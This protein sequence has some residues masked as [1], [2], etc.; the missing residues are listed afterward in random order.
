MLRQILLQRESFS[1]FL[2]F[3]F[4]Q[5]L[6]LEAEEWKEGGLVEEKGPSEETVH[7]A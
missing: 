7:R 6:R 4:D 5:L 3:R 2:Q 1:K